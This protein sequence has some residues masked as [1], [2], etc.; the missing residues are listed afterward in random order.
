MTFASP[1]QMQCKDLI[2]PSNSV[3]LPMR[4]KQTARTGQKTLIA[5]RNPKGIDRGKNQ[6]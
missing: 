2:I 5:E 3:S 1:I 4:E 6:T